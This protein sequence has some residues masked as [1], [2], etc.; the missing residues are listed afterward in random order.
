MKHLKYFKPRTCTNPDLYLGRK[1]KRKKSDV[2]YVCLSTL[3]SHWFYHWWYSSS[4]R[5]VQ[6]T[7]LWKK[8]K[9]LLI[10]INWYLW[11]FFFFLSTLSHLRKQQEKFPSSHFCSPLAI[12]NSY[13][14]HWEAV[15]YYSST[16]KILLMSVPGEN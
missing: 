4:Q 3:H 5:N 11:I 12:F 10:F 15:L 2:F 1:E 14:S 6:L 8:A 9:N 16:Q 13:I 7:V